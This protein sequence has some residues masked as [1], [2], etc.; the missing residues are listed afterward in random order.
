MKTELTLRNC[1]SETARLKEFV[2][3]AGKLAGIEY[4]SAEKLLVAVEEAV[5][6]IILY[7]Y[8][9]RNGDIHLTAWTQ[10]G[11]LTFEIR[12]KGIAFDPTAAGNTDITLP[13]EKRQIGGLGLFLIREIM[14]G[15]N[16]RRCGDENILVLW[17][18]IHPEPDGS[19]YHEQYGR[20]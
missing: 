17:K 12:D 8:A 4:D 19:V 13:A 5:T 18:H 16:Y 2:L 14:D 3:T 10:D 7:A 6:N 15:I 20:D 9:E 1:I 11:C